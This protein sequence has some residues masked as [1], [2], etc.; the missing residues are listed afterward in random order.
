MKLNGLF[1]S[2]QKCN[3]QLLKPSHPN[4]LCNTFTEVLGISQQLRRQNIVQIAKILFYRVMK[5]LWSPSDVFTNVR[6]EDTQWQI[7]VSIDR[8]K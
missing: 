2:W 3:G 7:E 6:E 5:K 8:F 1:S 4:H